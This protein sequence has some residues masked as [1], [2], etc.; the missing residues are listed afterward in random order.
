MYVWFEAVMGYYSASLH[1]A[2]N[3]GKPELWKRLV[4]ND[5]AEHY[6]FMAK[7]N[8]PFH[9]IIWP[10]ML[11]GCNLHLPY[12]VPANEYLYSILRNFLNLGDTQFGYQII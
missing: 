10:A 2:K 7:D 1:W 4:G 11:S 3:Q 6:Y 9:T 5:E 8:I 12:D